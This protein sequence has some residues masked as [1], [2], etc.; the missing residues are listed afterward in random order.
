MPFDS[1]TFESL[2]VHDMP[3]QLR[4]KLHFPNGS[5]VPDHVKMNS[6]YM[7]SNVVSLGGLSKPFKSVHRSDKVV[8]FNNHNATACVGRRRCIPFLSRPDSHAVVLH[9]RSECNPYKYK[10]QE[11]NTTV[12]KTAVMNK[13][14]RLLVVNVVKVN[15]A[16]GLIDFATNTNT[17]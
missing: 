17:S 11:A 9:F 12:V 7:A 1:V 6:L 14:E 5:P 10:C 8:S 16:L 2:Y 3:S 13:Y 15:L 4:K